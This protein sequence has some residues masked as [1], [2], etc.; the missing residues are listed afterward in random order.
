MLDPAVVSRPCAQHLPAVRPAM[1]NVK[2]HVQRH[3][4]ASNVKPHGLPLPSF[5]LLPHLLFHSLRYITQSSRITHGTSLGNECDKHVSVTG[6]P[7]AVHRPG[8]ESLMPP[9]PVRPNF[10]T[11]SRT[12][13]VI[14]FLFFSSSEGFSRPAR[15]QTVE[16]ASPSDEA[17][18]NGFL[19]LDASIRRK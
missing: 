14:S 5:S 19:M 4:V 15:K 2:R 6:P 10:N 12:G 18:R 1:R 9:L 7:A 16:G 17:E 3:C 11:V 8:L 13:I